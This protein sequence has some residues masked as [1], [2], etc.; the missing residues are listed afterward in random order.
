MLLKDSHPEEALS[1]LE[2]AASNLPKEQQ[3]H[4]LIAQAYTEMQ[5]FED[6]KSRWDLAEKYSSNR[7]GVVHAHANAETAVGRFDVAESILRGAIDQDLAVAE[8]FFL[9]TKT[10][11]MT[12]TDLPLIDRSFYKA[13]RQAGK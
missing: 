10:K 9:L 12:A 2:L 8:S 7:A 13:A 6:A 11:K 5:R 1:V 4:A 3:P